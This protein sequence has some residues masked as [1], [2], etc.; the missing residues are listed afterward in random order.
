MNSRDLRDVILELGFDALVDYFCQFYSS[1]NKRI[2]MSPLWDS[3]AT[4]K[5]HETRH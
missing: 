4:N 2:C 5:L 1:L 3:L